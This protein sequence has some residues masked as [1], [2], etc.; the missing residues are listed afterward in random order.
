MLFV[1]THIPESF[2]ISNDELRKDYIGELESLNKARDMKNK[3]KCKELVSHMIN[4]LS[5]DD[6][7]KVILAT[8]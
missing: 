7:E 2:E 6:Y 5:M 4:L 1:I 8:K 3:P